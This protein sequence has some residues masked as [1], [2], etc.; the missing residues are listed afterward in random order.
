M[1]SFSRT[2]AIALVGL[3]IGLSATSAHAGILGDVAGKVAGKVLGLDAIAAGA[4]A[5]RAQREQQRQQQQQQQQ[6]QAP[7]RTG[8]FDYLS[9]KPY[10]DCLHLYYS[11]GTFQM[12]AGLS[13][14]QQAAYHEKGRRYCN[15]TFYGHD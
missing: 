6:A 1:T 14:A 2:I 4:A 3:T 11:P 10:M 15:R 12:P 5:G 13:Q 9:N 7:A 8:Q